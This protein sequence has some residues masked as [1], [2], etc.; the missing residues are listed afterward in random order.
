[1]DSEFEGGASSTGG[2]SAPPPQ[3][4]PRM[5]GRLKQNYSFWKT[6]VRSQLVLSWILAGFPLKWADG[7]PA[8]VWLANHSSAYEH[9]G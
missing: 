2:S 7:P 9:T 1:M 4:P 8:P 5:R 6:F 3:P